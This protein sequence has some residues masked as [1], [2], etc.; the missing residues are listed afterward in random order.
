MGAAQAAPITILEP[1]HPR[2]PRRLKSRRLFEAAL[3]REALKESF[4]ML[5]PDIQWSNPV[6]FVVEVGAVLT[7]LFIIQ[8][9][10][11]TS[12]SQVPITYFIALDFWLFLTVL[13]ANFATALAE[14]RGKAQAESLRKTRSETPAYR[15]KPGGAVEEVLSTELRLGD[16]VV[17]AAG[18]LIPSDGEI[19]AGIA[20]VDE[21][22]ITG[23]SAPVIR[24]SGGDRSGVTGGTR[25]I[26][27]RIVV[28][29]TAAP[30][31]SFL[32]RMI[33]LVEGAVRQRTP[34]EIALSL[35]LSALTLA[36]LI[37][38][39]PLWPMA[40]NAEQYM[41]GYL[42]ITEP[43]KSLGTDVPTL[44]ALLVC[45]IPT[46]IGALLAAIGIAGMDRAL[47]ANIIAK[48][49]KAVETAGDIDIVLLDKTGTITVGNRHATEFIA[50]GTYTEKN[51]AKLSALASIADETPEGKSIVAH[52]KSMG[53][54]VTEMLIPAEAQSIAFSAQTRMS[55]IDLPD[56]TII[57]KGAPD[58]VIAFVRERQGIIP[59]TLQQTIDSIAF[60]GA[61]PLVVS[62]NAKVA[63]VVVLE[64]ILKSGMRERFERLRNMGLRTVMITGDNTLTAATI[65][66]QAGVDDFVAQAT[67]E[68]KLAY[69]RKEQAD[70]KLVAMMGD[71]TNDAPA[72]AQA[73]VGLAM[74][75][76]T[77]AAK[78]AGN[79]VD[80][81]SDPT[82]L[83]EVVEVGKQ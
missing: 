47:Q 39:V 55:G 58:A 57:R 37:V 21:S 32:D 64:D 7:L 20:S 11:S 59:A 8:A 36:F 30:G 73:D 1:E 54:S 83:I 24:E 66:K 16:N 15:L 61:T 42:G 52:A 12:A 77:Q 34:N 9:I 22:A 74:N 4:A 26:S 38:V 50:V 71:G 75:S 10:V 67:P 81:D 44:V 17:V 70:G 29:V 78:E 68:T 5:R 27:D 60:K 49:G 6:M 2:P 48:S 14:A 3:V 31:Q 25:V 28:K 76:G 53:V 79:M 65:A 46:T 82:K 62:E 63:G 72:L 56:G 23:E 69:I 51:L 80:L 45:L 13:F 33:A 43:L 35:A 40:Y 19:I 41:M 18:Q